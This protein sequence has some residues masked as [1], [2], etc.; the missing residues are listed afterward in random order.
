MRKALAITILTLAPWAVGAVEVNVSNTTINVPTPQGFAQLTPDI[1]PLYTVALNT[2]NPNN[3]RLVMFVDEE[4]IPFALAGE[5][6]NLNRF[7]NIEVMRRFESITATK[8]DFLELQTLM[9]DSLDAQ[10]AKF[11]ALIPGKMEEL[12]TRLSETLDLELILSVSNIVPL[13]V[14]RETPRMTAHSMFVKFNR[15]NGS[16][17]TDFIV[18]L[19]TTYLFVKGKILFIYVYGGPQDLSW[20]REQTA[21]LID[22]I[23]ATN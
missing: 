22:T 5:T 16:T 1:Q 9:R 3:R 11:E 20:T 14:H 21:R 12:S 6:P 7:I 18:T 10:I 13:P 17:V 2:T 8:S 15:S 19:T 4:I 23:I